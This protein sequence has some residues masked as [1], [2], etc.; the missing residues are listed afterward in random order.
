MSCDGCRVLRKGCSDK[1]ILRTCLEWIDCAEAQ[2]HATLFV[3]RFYGRACLFS[4]IHDVQ[5]K[6]RPALFKSL[7]Y[8]ACGR[9]INPVFGAVGLLWSG[10]WDV[11][12]AAVEKVL[13]TGSLRQVP[14]AAISQSSEKVQSSPPK[15][16]ST[17]KRVTKNVSYYPH[18]VQPLYEDVQT[19]S[20]SGHAHHTV[21]Q[22]ESFDICQQKQIG[23]LD[24]NLQ[25]RI[26]LAKTP[27]STLSQ[28]TFSKEEHDE[29][30]AESNASRKRLHSWTESSSDIGCLA[31]RRVRILEGITGNYASTPCKIDALFP[32]QQAKSMPT[33]YIDLNLTL[34][35]Y[36]A[37]SYESR[38]GVKTPPPCVSVCSESSTSDLSSPDI[39]FSPMTRDANAN[40]HKLELNSLFQADT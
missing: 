11:C 31:S 22:H 14:Q 21:Q 4:F 15:A 39:T 3:A 19:A 8:E 29:L 37:A 40:N 26:K 34:S 18:L 36:G 35:S 28:R 1:C 7:L 6:Q 32:V 30:F 38:L 25:P 23:R 9:T 2:A 20:L 12:H 13:R 24:A 16:Q 27:S 33:D 10:K 5:E 17:L